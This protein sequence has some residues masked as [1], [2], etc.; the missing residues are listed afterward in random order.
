MPKWRRDAQLDAEEKLLFCG[1]RYSRSGLDRLV[2]R[3]YRLLDLISFL[4][5]DLRVRAWTI[6]GNQGTPGCKNHSDF[7]R[8]YGLKC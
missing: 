8:L 4:T 3:C 6:G 5:A 2:R 1:G 7:E